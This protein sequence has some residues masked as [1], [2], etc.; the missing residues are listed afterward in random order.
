MTSSPTQFLACA[1][2]IA[3]LSAEDSVCRAAV[4]RA[5]YAA[6]HAAKRFHESLAMPGLIMTARGRHEQLLNQ[7][8]FPGISSKNDRYKISVA[9]SKSLRLAYASR[10]DADYYLHVSMP[11]DRASETIQAARAV[12]DQA[13]KWTAKSAM[14]NG[15]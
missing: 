2:R 6:Y 8:A 15:A 1:E 12:H 13:L 9:L 3:A 4:S 11:T 7:L 5:Y 14:A 10:I